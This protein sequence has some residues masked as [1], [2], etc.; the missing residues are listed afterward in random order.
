MWGQAAHSSRLN[1]YGSYEIVAVGKAYDAIASAMESCAAVQRAADG[2]DVV[3]ADR[4]Q[5]VAAWLSSWA[6]RRVW[7]PAW[8]LKRSCG[9]SSLTRHL[10]VRLILGLPSAQPALST[11]GRA[12]GE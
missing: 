10:P 7:R 2:A 3:E 12:A 8:G 9:E 5:Q 4:W 6:W 11:P 1:G